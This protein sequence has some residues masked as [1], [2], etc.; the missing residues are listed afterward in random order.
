MQI[1]CFFLNFA[2]LNCRFLCIY[3]RFL[4]NDLLVFIIEEVP[5]FGLD[6]D[7]Q[8]CRKQKVPTSHSTILYIFR[9]WYSAHFLLDFSPTLCIYL[10]VLPFY[11]KFSTLSFPLFPLF[12]PQITPTGFPHPLR[13]KI[14]TSLQ[15][16]LENRTVWCRDSSYLQTVHERQHY[17]EANYNPNSGSPGNVGMF[18]RGVLPSHILT[19]LYVDT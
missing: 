17:D 2:S 14:G 1:N 12:I 15:V 3:C 8:P 11:V 19:L 4:Y 9:Y 6:T 10:C 18:M 5:I 7:A 16:G 13:T